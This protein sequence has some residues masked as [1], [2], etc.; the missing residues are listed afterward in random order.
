MKSYYQEV[1]EQTAEAQ[2]DRDAVETAIK[3]AQPFEVGAPDQ[4]TDMPLHQQDR[5]KPDC[6]LECARMAE[7]RQTGDDPG[8][9]VYKDSAIEQGLYDPDRGTDATRFVDVIN[10][11][12]GVE[13][14]LTHAEGPQDIKDALDNGK[15]VIVCV[16][17][18]EFYRGQYNLLND[19][20]GHAVVV[21]GADEEPDGSWQFAVNDPNSE[22]PNIPVDGERFLQAWDSANKPMITV[23]KTGGI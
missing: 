13:A 18:Y 8:L 3:D 12:P 19:G 21:T 5:A 17:A 2:L 9:G 1:P 20:S 16:D 4:M 14:Q 11:R 7:H 6:L 23:E 15:S 10:E 22:V